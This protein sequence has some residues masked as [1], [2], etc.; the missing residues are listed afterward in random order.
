MGMLDEWS[1]RAISRREGPV[2][3]LGGETGSVEDMVKRDLILEFATRPD[4]RRAYLTRV[5]FPPQTDSAL[6]VCI[7]S[8]RPDDQAVVARVGDILRRRYSKDTALEILFLTPEQ[9]AEIAGVSRPFFSGV[10]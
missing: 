5:A 9:D 2:Q 4:I 8:R 7:L 3:F 10:G 1:R 6:A